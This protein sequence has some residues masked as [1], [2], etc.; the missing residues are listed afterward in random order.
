MTDLYTTYLLCRFFRQDPKSVRIL[1]IDAHPKGNLDILWS[2]LFHSYTRLGHLKNVSSI[3]YRQ[4]IWAQPQQ[5]SEIDISQLRKKAPSYLSDFREHVLKQFDIDYQTNPQ[6][7]C[8][9]LKI[10]FLVR[11]NYVAHPRNPSGKIGRRL[12]DERQILKELKMKFSEYSNINFTWNHFEELSIAEQLKII[13]ETDI[14]VG[15]HGAGLTHVLFL[16]SNRILIE[17][18]NIP[19]GVSHFDLLASMNNVIYQRCLIN[20]GSVETTKE[21]YDCITKKLVKVCPSV[22]LSPILLKVQR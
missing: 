21:I 20:V 9:S 1:F 13:I 18:L 11:H 16:K 10:F 3:L 17:L 6:L 12:P 14:F 4:L 5:Q 2:Q 22:T 7:N 15:I 8:Q 19:R